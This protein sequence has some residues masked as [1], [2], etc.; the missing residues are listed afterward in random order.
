MIVP[1]WRELAE[2]NDLTTMN[3]RYDYRYG[4]YLLLRDL[5]WVV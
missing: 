2:P 5:E 3:Y 4:R 1:F